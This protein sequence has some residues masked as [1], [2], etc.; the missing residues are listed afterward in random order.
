MLK[1][2]QKFLLILLIGLTIVLPNSQVWADE[3]FNDMA[4]WSDQDTQDLLIDQMNAQIFSGEYEDKTIKGL[5]EFYS[6]ALQIASTIENDV[7][8]II[9][10]TKLSELEKQQQITALS[11]KIYHFSPASYE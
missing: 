10:D 11:E 7:V 2:I 3:R 8:S 1:Q 4:Y 9:K 6:E 5:E